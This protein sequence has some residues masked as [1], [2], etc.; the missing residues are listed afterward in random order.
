MT[1]IKALKPLLWLFLAISV[2]A[3]AALVVKYRVGLGALDRWLNQRTELPAFQFRRL[4]TDDTPPSIPS[5]DALESSERF[6]A[7]RL[8]AR[9]KLA[10]LLAVT[11]TM[12]VAVEEHGGDPRDGLTEQ[13]L[14]MTT[15]EG[16]LLPMFL[17]RPT[18]SQRL[19]AVVVVAGHGEGIVS[20]A[21]HYPDYHKSIGLELARAGFAVLMVEK[22]GFGYLYQMGEGSD[23]MDSAALQGHELIHGRSLPGVWTGDVLA[24]ISY[25]T[26][27]QDIDAAR[28]GLYGFS[29]GGVVALYAAA[30]D[31]RVACVAAGSCVTPFSEMF[32]YSWRSP[33]E[34]VPR[35]AQWLEMT[36]IVSMVAPR[37]VLAQWGELDTVKGS[38]QASL[39]P[40]A[41]GVMEAARDGAFTLLRAQASVEMHVSPMLGHEVDPDPVIDFLRRHLAHGS[42]PAAESPGP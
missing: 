20:L 41:R 5:S 4:Y 16:V 30:L 13:R 31:P 10:E 36:D 40:G 19:P 26:T 25:L 42:P 39:T 17:L 32:K 29:S 35:I 33:G 21:G 11:R 1:V 7:W 15:A 37:P 27:R 9:E 14:L 24:G 2:A 8:R 3:N 22:R 6:E 28:I 18:G 34:A 38:R 23:A 12:P